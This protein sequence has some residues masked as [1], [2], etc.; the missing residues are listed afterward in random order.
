MGSGV[1]V[2]L[3]VLGEALPAS[4]AARALRLASWLAITAG[5]AGL[6]NGSGDPFLRSLSIS[7]RRSFQSVN[8]V[9]QTSSVFEF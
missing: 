5:V 9:V 2:G 6:A 7:V 4:R 8:T 1:L 3:L